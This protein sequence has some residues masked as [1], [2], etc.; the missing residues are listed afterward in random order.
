[1]LP[2]D[3]QSYDFRL[4]PSLIAREPL[5]RGTERLL[6]IDRRTQSW[7]HRTF[8]DLPALLAPADCLVVNDT[9]VIWARLRA[10]RA[11]GGAVELLLHRELAP[12]SW[13]ALLKPASKC[14]VGET[15]TVSKELRVTITA[16]HPEGL[17][18]VALQTDVP[19]EKILDEAGHVP[20]PPYLGREDFPADRVNYQT[21]FA[22]NPGAVAAPT[23]GLHFTPAL[24]AALRQRGIAS[25]A[26]TLHVGLGTFQPLRPRQ[27]QTGQLHAERYAITPPAAAAINACRRR[28]GRV[29]AVGTTTVRTLEQ[30]ALDHRGMVSAGGGETTLFITPGFRFQAVDGLVTNFH[31]PRSSLLLLVCAFG[32]R[33]LV[34]A[35]YQEAIA[36]G[37]RFY[38]Y[39][40]A[41]LIV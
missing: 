26:V 2:A 41:M 11:S 13:E 16:K 19:L 8:A 21:M 6:V 15:L 22:K 23:A 4:P 1:M 7:Q 30:S 18:T 37:Y 24:L 17:A 34:L 10:I 29:V 31:L 20:L 28:G 27:L 40:D 3:L 35:A 12:G 9:K 32:G 5:A 36:A 33:D 25:T 39:G 14:R 38:S